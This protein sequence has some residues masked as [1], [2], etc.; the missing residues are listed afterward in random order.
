[1]SARRAPWGLM[2]ATTSVWGV[3]FAWVL[4]AVLNPAQAQ[5]PP[6]MPLP[7]IK[8]ADEGNG[9]AA[10]PGTPSRFGLGDQ[11]VYKTVGNLT[12]CDLNTYGSDPV[13]GV[14]K[15]CEIQRIE[16]DPAVVLPVF[17]A[18]PIAP[19]GAG[20]LPGQL[21]GAQQ[22]V[23]AKGTNNAGTWLNGWCKTAYGWSGWTRIVKPDFTGDVIP[24]WMEE[25]RKAGVEMAWAGMW[26]AGTTPIY[27]LPTSE[28]MR[29]IGT[30]LLAVDVPVPPAPAPVVAYTVASST[31][32]DGKRPAYR[33]DA[34]GALVVTTSRVQGG[35]VCD[36]NRAKVVKPGALY[37]GVS[38][39][40]LLA[41]CKAVK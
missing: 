36:C 23:Y 29:D 8:M 38:P 6:V 33:L 14:V 4:M 25:A 28:M 27:D 17:Q 26:F 7:W 35:A 20:C 19:P 1:M 40:P 9:F 13:P 15:V 34:A 16:Q 24:I 11:W 10:T 22:A 18:A 32:A 37:C 3:F 30:K 5:T 2:L 21:G 39:A 41:L 31:S 12:T